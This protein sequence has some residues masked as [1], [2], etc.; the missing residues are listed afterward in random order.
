MKNIICFI[1]VCVFLFFG[2]LPEVRS[3]NSPPGRAEFS[4]PL[5]MDLAS[6][7]VIQT[8]A[9]DFSFNEFLSNQ[10]IILFENK[11]VN[12]DAFIRNIHFLFG[13]SKLNLCIYFLC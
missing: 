9:F 5:H 12:T 7:T 1:L 11:P 3:E 13:Y 2:L 6:N 4:A 8:S 10:N